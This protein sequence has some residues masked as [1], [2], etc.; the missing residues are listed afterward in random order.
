MQ[1]KEFLLFYKR[2]NQIGK[3]SENKKYYNCYFDNFWA[4]FYFNIQRS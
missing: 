2:E 1:K 4:L 3:I